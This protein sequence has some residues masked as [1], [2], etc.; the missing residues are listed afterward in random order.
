M[1]IYKRLAVHNRQSVLAEQAH[2]LRQDMPFRLLHDTALQDLRR[3]AVF[4]CNSL[5]EDDRTAV[6]D[7]ID[8]VNGSTGQTWSP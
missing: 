6:T 4:N 5:L 8:E 2:S 1:I 3:I 7:L